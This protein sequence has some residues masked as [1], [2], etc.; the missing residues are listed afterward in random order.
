MAGTQLSDTDD[1]RA[2]TVE[3]AQDI[4]K[5]AD[6]LEQV[7]VR[8]RDGGY[9]TDAVLRATARAILDRGDV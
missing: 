4:P 9:A 1:R 5:T 3:R 2:R 6:R 7:R 8:V